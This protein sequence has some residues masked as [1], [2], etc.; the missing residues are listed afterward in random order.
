MITKYNTYIKENNDIVAD[1]Q[2]LDSVIDDLNKEFPTNIFDIV[3]FSNSN[4]FDII[5]KN[6]NKFF[7]I[8]FYDDMYINIQRIGEVY[9]ICNIN[10]YYD[11]KL[12]KEKILIGYIIEYL[13]RSVVV[14][15][16]TIKMNLKTLLNKILLNEY[17]LE[18]FIQLLKSNMLPTEMIT[19]YKYLIDAN[20]FD[21]I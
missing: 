20:N 7:R 8:T 18:E 1:F 11:K 6:I 2:Y 21:L 16:L 15:S 5:A 19:K 12:L 10:I 13:N 4:H 3:R 9:G 14:I 17:F